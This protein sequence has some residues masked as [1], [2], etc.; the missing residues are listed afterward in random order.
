MGQEGMRGRESI[1]KK[2][3]QKHK[4][5]GKIKNRTAE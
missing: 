4:S 3:K 2:T 5:T 1:G